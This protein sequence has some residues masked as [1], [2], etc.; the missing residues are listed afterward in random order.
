MPRHVGRVNAEGYLKSGKEMAEVAE[1]VARAAGFT[2]GGRSLLVRSR[3][4][5][6]R[7]ALDPKADLGIGEVHFPELAI[8]GG[9]PQPAPMPIRCCGLAARPVSGGAA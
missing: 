5:A 3:Q 7:C 8:S 4:I 1:E 9:A 6:E 2:D